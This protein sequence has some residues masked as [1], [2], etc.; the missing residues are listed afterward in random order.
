[1]TKPEPLPPPLTAA[2]PR[3]VLEAVATNA[4]L[5]RE[6]VVQR[7]LIDAAVAATP[8]P[9]LRQKMSG[10]FINMLQGKGAG[11][12]ALQGALAQRALRRGSPSQGRPR[13]GARGRLATGE[14]WRVRG[15]CR[16]L[17]GGRALSHRDT[18]LRAFTRCFTHGTRR[19]RPEALM[20]APPR[21]WEPRAAGVAAHRGG[22][23]CG[24]A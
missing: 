6:H 1:M 22:G 9:R 10:A 3:A 21:R 5:Q 23:A 16:R 13:G 15:R 8:H 19:R 14:A 18:E 7:E 24:P 4:A 17:E 12:S 20:M 2:E 11:F